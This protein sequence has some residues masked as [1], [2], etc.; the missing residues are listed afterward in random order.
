[1]FSQVISIKPIDRAYQHRQAT[2]HGR[3][4]RSSAGP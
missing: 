4:Y 3:L 1:M 2:A